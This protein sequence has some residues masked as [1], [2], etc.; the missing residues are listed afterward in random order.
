[1]TSTFQTHGQHVSLARRISAPRIAPYLAAT[2][3]NHRNALRLYGWNI[4]LSGAVY[5]ALHVFEIVLRNA[6]DHQLC[7]WN[8]TQSDRVTGTRHSSDWLLDPAR[9]LQRLLNRDLAKAQARARTALRAAGRAAGHAD[10]LT[11]MSFGTWRFLLPDKDR[12]RQL[13]WSQALHRAFPHG[14]VAARSL[15]ADVDSI[16]RIR[17]RVAHLEP[18]LAQGAVRA[19]YLAMRRVLAA[20]DP[21]AEQWFTSRQRIT[22]VL[23]ARPT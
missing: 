13:L 1:M 3:Y 2:A 16:Y 9:L 18:L 15:V 23:R 21:V 5:E 19:E 10:V 17:N 4:D 6:I 22:A 7:M 14:E 11:Q 12:G 8:A 20:I